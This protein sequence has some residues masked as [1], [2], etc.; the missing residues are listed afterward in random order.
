MPVCT[1][2]KEDKPED[3]FYWEKRR[4]KPMSAC[5]ACNIASSV[6]WAKRNKSHIKEKNHQWYARKVGKDPSECTRRKFTPE[7]W[8][9][10]ERVRAKQK[11]AN[12]KDYY[13]AFHQKRYQE[14]KSEV[15]AINKRWRSE[16][17]ERMNAWQREQHRLNPAI[18]IARQAQRKARKMQAEPKWLTAIQKA[19]IR[20]MYEI[21]RA[22]SIQT[23]L[24]HDVDHIF[25]LVN[26][27]FS[28]LHVP[29]NL[30]VMLSTENK[31][32]STYFPDEFSHM[33]FHE[34][35]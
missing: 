22:R 14:K 13:R 25:P 18:A 31:K 29:W 10:K 12:N 11:Y 8:K 20:E 28:G 15:A 30:R 19:Q 23:G 7:E 6:A 9:A 16:N 34:A 26:K 5:K 21:A 3:M 27:Q 35:R 2:C 32:K 4:G 24:Q 1:K 17:K 33:R